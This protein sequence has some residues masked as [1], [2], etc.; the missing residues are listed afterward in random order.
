MTVVVEPISEEAVADHAKQALANED[1]V[2]QAL[3]DHP[4][5][6]YSDICHSAGWLDDDGQPM[7]ARVQR[8]M[9]TLAADKLIEKPRRGARW[10]ITAKG[11]KTI[12]DTN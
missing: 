10:K 9:Q 4:D 5:W 7:K 12:A 2:L 6:S 8:A 11:E 1:V 3:R